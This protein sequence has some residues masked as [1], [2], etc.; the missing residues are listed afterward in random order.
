MPETLTLDSFSGKMQGK[1]CQLKC[2]N[3]FCHYANVMYTAHV[4]KKW[5][6]VLG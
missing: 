3:F 1:Y 4:V 5:L 2:E 6:V